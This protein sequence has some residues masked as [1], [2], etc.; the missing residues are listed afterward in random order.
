MFFGAVA[1][2]LFEPDSILIGNLPLVLWITPVIVG[3]RLTFGRGRRCIFA[4]AVG[5]ALGA[6]LAVACIAISS[7][8]SFS[9]WFG[10]LVVVVFGCIGG[11]ILG[12]AT[13]LIMEGVTLR[14]RRI[15]EQH[16]DCGRQPR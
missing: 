10:P 12:A 11:A 6:T 15:V 2:A 13:R 16:G 3:I 4:G 1:A 8:L 14:D 7:Q 9:I 5:G